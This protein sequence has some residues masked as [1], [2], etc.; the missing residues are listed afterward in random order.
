MRYWQPGPCLLRVLA[1]CPVSIAKT[2]VPRAN[3]QYLEVFLSADTGVVE[4]PDDLA[5]AIGGYMRLSRNEVAPLGA[6]GPGPHTLAVTV[7]GLTYENLSALGPT[8][9]VYPVGA[10]TLATGTLP[11]TVRGSRLSVV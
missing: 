7:W 3:A 8:G 2:R 1:Q 5:T 6:I 9:H 4:R 10:E 11:F